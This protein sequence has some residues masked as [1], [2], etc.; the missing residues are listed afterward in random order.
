MPDAKLKLSLLSGAFAVCRLKRDRAVPDWATAGDFFSVTRTR[1]EL[2][3]VCPESVVPE[4]VTCEKGWRCLK[5]R[6]TLDFALVGILASMVVPLAEAGISV[7]VVSTYDTD[8]LLLKE[9]DL[10]KAARSLAEAGHTV[11]L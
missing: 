5:V 3:I 9:R 2:S 4:D 7:F 6:G 11:D 1:D 8:Y 10:E